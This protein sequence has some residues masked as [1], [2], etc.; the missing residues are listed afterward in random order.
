MCITFEHGWNHVQG[1]DGWFVENDR[2]SVTSTDCIHNM[3][4]HFVRGATL[5]IPAVANNFAFHSFAVSFFYRM[6]SMYWFDGFMANNCPGER[7]ATFSIGVRDDSNTFRI[8]M[9]DHFF[10]IR[11]YALGVRI[12][13]RHVA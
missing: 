7:G 4:G 9:N 13:K 11:K 3:C 10:D 12:R 8:R 5:Q 2:V 6:E 1:L